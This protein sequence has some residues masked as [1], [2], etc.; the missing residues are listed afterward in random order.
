M[1]W[2]FALGVL[3]VLFLLSGWENF[4]KRIPGLRSRRRA[5]RALT[6]L[7]V[8]AAVVLAELGAAGALDRF[9]PTVEA[10]K[11]HWLGIDWDPTAFATLLLVLA[12]IALVFVTFVVTWLGW[13]QQRELA[14]GL[15]RREEI[16]KVIAALHSAVALTRADS[17]L[18]AQLEGF[19]SRDE[20]L[21]RI[22]TLADTLSADIAA[23]QL[24]TDMLYLIAVRI[25][26]IYRPT[27]EIRTATLRLSG[28]L[29]IM[30][31]DAKGRRLL[32]DMAAKHHEDVDLFMKA[33]RDTEHNLWDAAQAFLSSS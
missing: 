31:I 13:A 10:A 8:G 22:A 29:L 2:L 20:T 27:E 7:I 9:V 23:I 33:I 21:D 28:R 6:L 24:S 17:A 11:V 15:W 26:T 32:A 4:R 19:D 16:T 30:R 5:I 1:V 18:T 12:T 25:P 3:V 14:V